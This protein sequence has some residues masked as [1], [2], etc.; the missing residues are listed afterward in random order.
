MAILQKIPPPLIATFSSKIDYS[1]FNSN[2]PWVNELIDYFGRPKKEWMELTHKYQQG[3]A[4]F[5]WAKVKSQD[6]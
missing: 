5:K 3:T 2:L 6:Q 4:I 1:N